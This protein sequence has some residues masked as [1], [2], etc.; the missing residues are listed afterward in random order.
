[1]KIKI[2]FTIPNFNTAGSGKVVY[3]LVKGI[4][5]EKFA[6]EILVKHT[7]GDFYKEVEKLGVP[8][9]K[10]PYETHYY[11]LWSFPFRL[12]KVVRFFKKLE[13]DIIHSWHYSSDFSE[14]L[15]ARLASVKF[16]YTKKNM[17]WGNKAWVWKSK[18]SSYIVTINTTMHNQFFMGFKNIV[19]I[20]VGIDTSYF[21]PQKRNYK[22]DGIDLLNKFV[23]I[24]VANMTPIKGIEVLI[25]SFKILE[26]ETNQELV[27][28]LVGKKNTEYGQKL[29][30]LSKFRENI[31]FTGKKI[32]VRPYLAE[33][34]LFI[35]S[36]LDDGEGQGVA[37]LEAMAMGVP[38]IASKVTGLTDIMKGYENNLF[39]PGDSIDL[40]VKIKQEIF[41]NK[42]SKE[43]TPIQ[44]SSIFKKSH[45]IEDYSKLYFKILQ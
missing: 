12:R 45:M 36:T 31:Y 18:L 42:N 40:T 13:V 33:A 14:A 1:M 41:S 5:K 28:F 22:I 38:V 43:K 7:K 8:I 15:A 35:I 20:P 27:L 3:D 34:D 2:L 29:I 19:Y 11:P 44:L 37:P 23:I 26:N 32:D 4:D 30:R 24:S 9:H 17:A 21:K 6:P 39:N 25:E 10:F 16:I